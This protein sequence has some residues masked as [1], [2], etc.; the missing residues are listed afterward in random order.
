[1]IPSDAEI[2]AL[3][4]RYAPSRA[5]FEKVFTHCRIVCRIA[6][7]LAAGKGL[8]VEL[9]RA[10]SLLHDIGVY[11]LGAG[12]NYI[13][14]GLLG[15]ELLREAGL[16]E[17]LRR[18]CSCHT[19]VGLTAEDI[20]RQA[21]PLP[22]GDYL[23]AT[24]EEELVMYADKFH[25]KKTPPVFNSVAAYTETVSRFGP[26]KAARFAELVARYGEPGLAA[27]SREFGHPVR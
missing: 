6:G 14:H 15:H 7:E 16:P 12:E 2:Q 1:M 24:P 3:H 11:R 18:F 26:G 4:E 8:D 23:P 19:G 21:L 5:A 22:P 17:Q 20:G 9:V 13:R 27:L 25:S 10:G